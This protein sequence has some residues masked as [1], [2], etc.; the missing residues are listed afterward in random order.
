MGKG[1]AIQGWPFALVHAC[2]ANTHHTPHGFGSQMARKL[3]MAFFKQA[4]ILATYL[5]LKSVQGKLFQSS[6][7]VVVFSVGLTQR[8]KAYQQLS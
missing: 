7:F 2:A 3:P 5:F 6:C 1:A 4:T 8:V